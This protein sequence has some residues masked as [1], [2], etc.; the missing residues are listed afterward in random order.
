MVPIYT[1]IG[2]SENSVYKRRSTNLQIDRLGCLLKEVAFF[3]AVKKLFV[4]LQTITRSDTSDLC[5]LIGGGRIRTT[6]NNHLC[7]RDSR[8]ES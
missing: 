7:P 4:L 5:P 1:R 6:S 2:T 8:A 3:R